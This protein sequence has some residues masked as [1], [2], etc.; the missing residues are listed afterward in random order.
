MYTKRRLKTG[1]PFF[2]CPFQPFASAVPKGK[3]SAK[4]QEFA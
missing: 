4:P 1:K 3:I 2:I